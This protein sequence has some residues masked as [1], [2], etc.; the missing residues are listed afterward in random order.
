MKHSVASFM[1]LIVALASCALPQHYEDLK[2]LH[3]E[4]GNYILTLSTSTRPHVGKNQF[5]AR[6]TDPTGQAIS[7]ATVTFH[8]WMPAMH[9]GKKGVST[10]AGNYE[11]EVDLIMGGE[12]NISVEIERPG[13][14]KIREGFIIDA[15]PY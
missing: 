3:R 12:W 13:F 8:Y 4:R 5:R 11:T 2:V 1:L 6:L 10:D 9:G 15:G 7:N 14:E